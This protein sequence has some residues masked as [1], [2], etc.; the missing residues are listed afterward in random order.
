M[1]VLRGDSDA[2][3]SDDRMIPGKFLQLWFETIASRWVARATTHRSEYHQED[4]LD[5]HL[6]RCLSMTGKMVL[7]RQQCKNSQ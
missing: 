1:N 3:G 5:T 2:T 4:G 6:E 7:D